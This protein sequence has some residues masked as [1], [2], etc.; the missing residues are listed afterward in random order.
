MGVVEAIVSLSVSGITNALV[1]IRVG[2]RSQHARSDLQGSPFECLL[3]AFTIHLC[4]WAGLKEQNAR[5]EAVL[6]V[7]SVYFCHRQPFRF[8]RTMLLAFT[9]A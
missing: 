8:G 2:L 7:E 4:S 6:T 1:T 3:H 5:D 9:A